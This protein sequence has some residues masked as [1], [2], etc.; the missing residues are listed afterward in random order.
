MSWQYLIRMFV[1]FCLFLCHGV[2]EQTEQNLTEKKP[3]LSINKLVFCAMPA[4]LAGQ[5]LEK[6]Y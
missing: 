4:Y 6:H 2:V 3:S 5:F 1:S